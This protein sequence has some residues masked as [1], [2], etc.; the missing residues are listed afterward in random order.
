M[1]SRFGRQTLLLVLCVLL[2]PFVGDVARSEKPT[3][4]I[5]GVVKRDATYRDKV[6][7]V[8]IRDAENTEF[9]VVRDA[10]K[11]KA[12][13]GLVGATVKVTGY[14]RKSKANPNYDF[15]ID[16]LEYEVVEAPKGKAVPKPVAD[17]PAEGA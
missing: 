8:Y 12:L 16:V 11:G 9:L 14:V 6:I 17:S 2:V 13:L 3:T 15:M 7:G 5:T 4:T 1:P 10:E